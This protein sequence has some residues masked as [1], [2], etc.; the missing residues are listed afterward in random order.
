MLEII[1]LIWLC[2]SMGKVLRAKNRRPLLMQIL[3]V[4]TWFGA[5]VCGVIATMIFVAVTQGA[6]TLEGT[7]L[8]VSYLVALL[9]AALSVLVLFGVAWLLPPREAHAPVARAYEAGDGSI[10]LAPDNPYNPPRG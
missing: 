5:E 2:T 3:V 8:G 6:E 10:D 9:S 7:N 4:L 1:L